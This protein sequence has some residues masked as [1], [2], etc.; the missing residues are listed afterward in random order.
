MGKYN[1]LCVICKTPFWNS[2]PQA[3]CCSEE[4]RLTYKLRRDREYKAAR[5]VPKET[6]PPKPYKTPHVK[7]SADLEIVRAGLR[8]IVAGNIKCLRC[9]K[10]FKSKDVVVNR[11]CHTC[12]ISCE[13]MVDLVGYEV[14]TRGAH[15]KRRS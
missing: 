5:F 3:L 13:D 4:C 6:S 10:T 12:H 11:I 7:K 8:K 14:N 2:Q 15:G 9:G 1:K